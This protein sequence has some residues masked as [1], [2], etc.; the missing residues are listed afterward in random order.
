MAKVFSSK[1]SFWISG[2]VIALLFNLALYLFD[3]PIGMSDGYLPLEQYCGK[4]I[5]KGS[6][7]S[8]P[9]LDWQTGFLFGIM[10][11]AFIAAVLSGCWKFE[12][13]P[14]DMG[15]EFFPAFGKSVLKGF[16]GGFLVMLGMQIA[17]DSFFGQWA[18]A[19]QL[20]AGAWLFLITFF[21]TGTVL[22]ILLAKRAEG[23]G[24]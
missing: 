12:F 13:F 23:A 3:S 9:S 1:W 4:V 7:K 11:G 24:K 15:K 16:L 10:I 17:G 2:L 8:P 19:M 22:T 20:S 14:A 18:A 21:V 5:S 6:L